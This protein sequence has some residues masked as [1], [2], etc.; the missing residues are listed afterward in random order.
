MLITCLLIPRLSVSSP[1]G[2]LL[3]VVA[4]AFVNSKYWDAAL[5]FSVPDHFTTRAAFLF[6]TNGLIFWILVKLLPGIEVEGIL[7]ALLAPIV[8]TGVSLIINRYGDQ[9]DWMAILDYVIQT[10]KTLKGYFDH[11]ELQSRL[12]NA[13][14]L[15]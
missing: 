1:F 15:A 13:T 3:I 6:L 10:L 12:L 2:A 8:F 7:P 9:V 14:Q 5:F 11:A 4:L